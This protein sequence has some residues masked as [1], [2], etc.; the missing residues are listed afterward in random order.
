MNSVQKTLLESVLGFKLWIWYNE[1]AR[2]RDNE[3]KCSKINDYDIVIRAKKIF[4]G[5]YRPFNHE[6]MKYLRS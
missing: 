2:C 5:K 3:K 6:I 4:N 1:T